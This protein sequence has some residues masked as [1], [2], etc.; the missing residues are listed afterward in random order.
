LP[1][2]F[3]LAVGTAQPRK[4]LPRLVES[5]RRARD[6]SAGDLQLVLVGPREG[7]R[8]SATHELERAIDAANGHGWVHRAGYVT[9][10]VLAALYSTARAVAFPSL[11]EGFGLPALE[12]LACGAVLVASSA[13]ALP[14]VCGDAALLVPP[15]DVDALA[16]ALA[17]AVSDEVVRE[18]LRAAGPPQAARFTWE[19]TAQLTVAAYRAVVVR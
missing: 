8:G 4:N 18:R 17:S 6:A 19:R 12:A 7:G 3:V 5:V 1:G 16:A 14:E 2:E 10:E 13:G 15:E 9:D 11:Y